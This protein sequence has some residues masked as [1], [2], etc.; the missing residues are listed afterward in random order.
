MNFAAQRRDRAQELAPVPDEA[1]TKVLEVVGGQLGQ[2]RGVDGVVAERLFV[3]LHPEAVE[4]GCDVHARLP[5][6]THTASR[7]LTADCRFARLLAL[8]VP[9]QPSAPSLT[10]P[11]SGRAVRGKRND[12]TLIARL[13][14]R[15]LS[16]GL[17][18]PLSALQG[19]E[20]GARVAGG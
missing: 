14:R 17:Q 12:C 5:A 10:L 4:P 6:A 1:H 8:H 7:Y 19:G 9:L 15:S 3:L 11:A 18:E 16:S 2:D 20:G 13:D